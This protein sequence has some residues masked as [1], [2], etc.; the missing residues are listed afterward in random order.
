MAYEMSG[1]IKKGLK[2]K[3]T[4]A[5]DSSNSSR[6]YNGLNL[7][8]VESLESGAVNGLF[9]GTGAEIMASLYGATSNVDNI[10]IAYN[11]EEAVIYNG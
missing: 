11:T 7:N 9:V 5:Q 1:E 2:V 3:Y 8:T 4:S 10:S 6:T